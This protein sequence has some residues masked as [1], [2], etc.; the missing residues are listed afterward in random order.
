MLTYKPGVRKTPAK[1][2]YR[3]LVKFEGKPELTSGEQKLMN[4]TEVNSGDTVDAEIKLL[5]LTPFLNSLYKGMKFG[6]FEGSVLIGS[7]I[8][9]DV[10]NKS[11]EKDFINK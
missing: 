5:W 4:V 1:S 9:V 3:P 2:G 7:G 10:L 6:F 8:I 11:L